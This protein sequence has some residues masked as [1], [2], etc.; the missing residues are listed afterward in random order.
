MLKKKNNFNNFYVFGPSKVSIKF[1]WLK[2][3]NKK[4][5]IL[6]YLQIICQNEHKIGFFVVSFPYFFPYPPLYNEG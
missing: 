3:K 4:I 2:S 6:E 1:T 5:N